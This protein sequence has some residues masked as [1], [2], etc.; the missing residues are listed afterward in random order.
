MF[1]AFEEGRI[2]D[3]KEAFKQY[4]LSE[5]DMAK[6]EDFEAY[7]LYNLFLKGS[8]TEALEKLKRLTR[9]AESESSRH[10]A[11]LWLSLCYRKLG[12]I[13]E[14]IK[15]WQESSEIFED[16]EIVTE[17]KISL[18]SAINK[19]GRPVESKALLT[20][21][22][23]STTSSGGK[24]KIYRAIAQVEGELGN[25]EISAYCK[26]KALEFDP[27][28]KH[29]LF[30][31]AFQ[32]GEAGVGPLAISNYSIL[33]GI[34]SGNQFGINNFA[35]CAR[36]AGLLS[37]ASEKFKSSANYGNTLAMSNWG[38]M[39]LDAGFLDEAEEIAKKAAAVNDAHENVYDLLA[40]IS[41]KRKREAKE[42]EELKDKSFLFQKN[43]RKYIEARYKPAFDLSGFWTDGSRKILIM[44]VGNIITANWEAVPE[45]ALMMPRRDIAFSGVIEG[46]SMIVNYRNKQE[47]PG[48]LLG[49]ASDV[50]AKCLG[51]FDREEGALKLFPEDRDKSVSVRLL[52]AEE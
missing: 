3:A 21:L 38:D 23:T 29:E 47:K 6:R 17:C 51:Y 36:E 16:V 32:A 28:N 31:S 18:A 30:Q 44:I 35:V 19:D 9:N 50:E 27:H 11:L 8:D 37:I 25:K 22:L 34:D 5:N 2:D 13:G 10:I 14:E 41:E 49:S 1:S 52:R 15:L 4:A 24:S 42:W 40:R 7:F 45:G 43:S 26:D 46:E 12:Q 48:S 33:L 20:G 39:L